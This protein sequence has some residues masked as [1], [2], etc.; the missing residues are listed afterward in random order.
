[1][2]KPYGWFLTRSCDARGARRDFAWH[3]GGSPIRHI[4]ATLGRAPSTVSREITRCGG[5]HTYRAAEA[6][7]QAWARTR[8]PKLCRLATSLTLQRIVARKLS[9]DWSP[10][11]IAGWLKRAFPDQGTMR[12]S[13]ETIYRS[14]F[15]QARGV[16]RKE[17][18]GHLRSRRMMR[19][20]QRA[21]TAVSLAANH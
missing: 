6:D 7:A 9:L 14:L 21:S 19:W 5:A 16:L 1:V 4:A 13:H 8:R 10:E 17:L 11:Q 2:S 12:I 18:L 15:I 20:A 3:G